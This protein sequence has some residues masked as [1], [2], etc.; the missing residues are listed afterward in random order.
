MIAEAYLV[1]TICSISRVYPHC[2]SNSEQAITSQVIPQPAMDQCIR[3]ANA[4]NKNRKDMRATCLI[5]DPR[6]DYAR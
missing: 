5:G 3:Q 2:G 1:L 6:N 4:I